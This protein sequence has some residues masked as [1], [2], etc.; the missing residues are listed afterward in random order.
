M[1][2]SITGFFKDRKNDN[3]TI[4]KS[5]IKILNNWIENHYQK[6]EILLLAFVMIF[7]IKKSLNPDSFGGTRG[8][9]EALNQLCKIN[10]FSEK[11]TVYEK[12][13]KP[14]QRVIFR[15]G[16]LQQEDEVLD[17]KLLET[18][19]KKSRDFLKI[20]QDR[21]QDIL[22]KPGLSRAELLNE[23]S[24]FRNFQEKQILKYKMQI[25]D[26]IKDEEF[27]SKRAEGVIA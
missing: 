11:L 23:M 24:K 4:I 3:S 26:A 22:A 19:E 25:L 21:L 12:G 7:G 9:G 18:L 27:W 16:N 15:I 13:P 14:Y 10:D 17:V 20:A 1:L 6:I 2:E 8:V 5:Y